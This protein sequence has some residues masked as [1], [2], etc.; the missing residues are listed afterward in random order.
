M[1]PSAPSFEMS[2]VHRVEVHVALSY[3]IRENNACVAS[4]VLEVS[5]DGAGQIF[6]HPEDA[7]SAPVAP[8]FVLSIEDAWQSVLG[9]LDEQGHKRK[10]DG[11][12]QLLQDSEPLARV[13]GRSA[14][15]AA[16]LAAYHALRGTLPDEGLI[17]L[18]EVDEKNIKQ[19]QGVGGVPAKIMAVME[20][21]KKWKDKD[22]DPAKTIDTVIVAS[23]LNAR[24]ANGALVQGAGIKVVDLDEAVAS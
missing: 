21:N 3:G 23:T 15:G 4:L 2:P 10:F 7:V 24:E 8:D 18:A 12:W 11:R 20:A 16:A 17:V 6:H 5:T 1:T 13:T 19:L 9:L 14:S 22:K